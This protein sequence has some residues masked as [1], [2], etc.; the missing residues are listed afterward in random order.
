VGYVNPSD[1]LVVLAV[2]VLLY[3][4]VRLPELGGALWRGCGIK[5]MLSGE[6]KLH[7]ERRD[8]VMP[9]VEKQPPDG[10]QR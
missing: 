3:G 5:S 2:L 1:L 6:H 9:G 10:F 8:V 4:L 7:N